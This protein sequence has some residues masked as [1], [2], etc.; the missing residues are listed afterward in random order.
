MQ[1]NVYNDTPG[2][3]DF[4]LAARCST[5]VARVALR[6]STLNGNVRVQAVEK[7]GAQA[8]SDGRSVDAALIAELREAVWA[9]DAFIAIAAHELRN[10]LTPIVAQVDL[11]R[12]QLSMGRASLDTIDAGLE[13]LA[14]MTDQFVKRATTLLDVS[15]VTTG[16]LSLRPKLLAVTPLL[17]QIAASYAPLAAISRSTISIE[18]SNTI[19]LYADP[20]AVEQVVDNLISNAL[21]YGAGH[22]IVLSVSIEDDQTI[23]RVRDHGPGIPEDERARIFERFERAIGAEDRAGGFGVGLWIVVQLVEA[24]SGSVVVESSAGEGSTFIV[25]LPQYQEIK[26]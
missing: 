17:R 8:A 5:E 26:A 24:M 13:R 23:L 11:M 21:K 20:L 1:I 19:E 4:A 18:A 22:P 9:R 14:W 25:R 2:A 7:N 15:R 6:R 12:R 10:P 16:K 3:T